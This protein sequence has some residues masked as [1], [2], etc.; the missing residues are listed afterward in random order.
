[1]RGRQLTI[2]TL[3]AF[4]IFALTVAYYH[5]HTYL[6]STSY[7]IINLPNPAYSSNVSIEQAL[8]TR[9]TIREFADKPITV[10]QL[11]QLLWAAQGITS[12]EGWRTAP[13][14]GPT[15]PLELYVVAKNVTGLA[16]GVYHY[17]P[18][19]HSLEQISPVN[20][21]QDIYQASSQQAPLLQCPAVIIITGEYDRTIKKYGNRGVRY[22]HLE[23]G[24]AAEN[25]ELQAVSLHLGTVSMGGFSDAMV[26]KA[27]GISSTLTPLF[28]MPVGNPAQ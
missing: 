11:G 15:Y 20:K 4:I 8:K 2:V 19:L 17:V 23:A 5:F 10:Q 1:M 3:I 28:I 27:L 26:I 22:V 7:P 6:F 21:I 14:A 25:I 12:P 13:S 24:T 9:R 16:V 18:A